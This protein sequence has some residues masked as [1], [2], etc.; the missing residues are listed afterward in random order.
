M[1]RSGLRTAL[2]GVCGG[3]VARM[4]LAPAQV[5]AQRRRE[6]LL[7]FALLGFVLFGHCSR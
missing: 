2:V 6:P 4:L 1:A 7:P 5:G 3:L